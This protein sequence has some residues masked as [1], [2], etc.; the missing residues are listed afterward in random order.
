MV[1]SALITWLAFALGKSRLT[2]LLTVARILGSKKDLTFK[3]MAQSSS[4]SP[5]SS[6]LE[7]PWHAS[8]KRKTP[9][10]FSRSLVDSLIVL[11]IVYGL[12]L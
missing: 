5:V 8:H 3:K 6:V 10:L 11:K 1:T 9:L 4:P 12:R 7:F 2:L